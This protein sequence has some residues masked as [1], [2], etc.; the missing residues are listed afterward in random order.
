[1]LVAVAGSAAS[2][3]T[4]A[5]LF[6]ALPEIAADLGTTT[7]VISWLGIAP[8]VAFAVSMPLFGKLGD[9]YGHRNVFII[10]W[11]VAAVLSIAAAAAPNALSLI[12]LRTAGQL[13]GTSTSPAAYGVLARIFPA[14]ERAGPYSR[15]TVA[16]AVSPIVGVAIGGWLVSEIGWRAMFVAQGVVSA[17]AVLVAIVLLPQTPRRHGVRFDIAGVVTLA[18]GLTCTLLAVNRLRSWGIDHRG[19]QVML[20]VGISSLVAFVLVEQRVAEPLLSPAMF[21]NRS[22]T[23]AMGTSAFINSSFNGLD[24][25]TPFAAA[26]LFGYATAAIAWINAARALGF[27]TGA[28]VARRLLGRWSGRT[29]VLAGHGAVV[30][31]CFVVAFGTWNEDPVWFIGGLVLGAFGTGFG[32]PS[33][34]TAITNAVSDGDAGVANGANNMAHQIGASIGQTALIAIAADALPRELTWACFVAAGL[35]AASLVT[36]RQMR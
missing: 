24:V 21:R 16:L 1:M 10:G 18:V 34:A 17:F 15:V 32:R 36:A 20:V 25:L 9:L 19:I 30:A 2:S 8:A 7:S 31:A 11:A 27:A 28:T 4:G 26:A 23:S 33:I 6:G 5:L 29:V 12:V 14:E 22:V 3:F 35:A 13:A